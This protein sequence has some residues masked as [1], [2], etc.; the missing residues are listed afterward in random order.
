MGED[1]LRDLAMYKNYKDKSVIMASR[2][3]IGL[4]REQM[5]TLL[6]KKDRGRPTEASIEIKPKKYGEVL[7]VDHIP[8]TEALLKESTKAYIKDK[9]SDDS[10]SDGWVDVDQSDGGEWITDS[11]DEEGDE[12][13]GGDEWVTDSEGE[14]EN[15][16]GWKNVEE[17]DSSDSEEASESESPKAG[18]SKEP[19]SKKPRKTL[20]SESSETSKK[21]KNSQKSKSSETSKT[22]EKSVPL[23]DKEAIK[24]MA[25]NKIFTDEDFARIEGELIKKKV[26]NAR[27]RKAEAPSEKSEFVKLN[28]IEM[29]YKKRRTDKEAR[30]ES[31]KKGQEGREKY[32]YKDGRHSIHCSKTNAEKS[33]KKNFQMMRHKARGK[34]KKS[35][36][37]KQLSLKKHLIQQKKMK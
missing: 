16:D 18:S 24:E 27:K 6:H 2:T 30:M 7:A 33:K 17:E 10:D 3:L 29:I 5:P 14:E 9:K 11:D 12:K 36:R 25:L 13:D 31:M 35:F 22:T 37:D 32:G 34:I 1:L 26:T 8:G 20:K 15:D 23:E 4:Y 21:S 19:V 28:D